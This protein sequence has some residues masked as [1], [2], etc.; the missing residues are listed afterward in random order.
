[1]GKIAKKAV[2][3]IQC[4]VKNTLLQIAFLAILPTENTQMHW[5]TW[6]NRNSRERFSFLVTQ[7][8]TTY[9]HVFL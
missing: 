2:F 8:L 1:V 4:H 7:R 6:I 9:T 3:K 5:I